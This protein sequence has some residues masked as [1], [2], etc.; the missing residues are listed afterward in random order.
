MLRNDPSYC[1]TQTY[2]SRKTITGRI[3]LTTVL[4][5][6]LGQGFFLHAC[7]FRPAPGQDLPPCL[8]AGFVQVR[9]RISTPL[10]QVT[11]QGVNTDQ[12]DQPPSTK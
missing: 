10:P 8:G 1:K 5:Y 7:S 9:E 6:L 11:L 12:L 3:E 4:M 2:T